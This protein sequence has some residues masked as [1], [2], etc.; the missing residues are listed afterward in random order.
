MTTIRMDNEPQIDSV[1]AVTPTEA[2]HIDP[3]HNTKTAVKK[4]KGQGA[5]IWI[6]VLGDTHR[7]LAEADDHMLTDLLRTGANIIQADPPQLL[8][9]YLQERGLHP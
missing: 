7:A 5:R 2:I 3:C 1:F 9:E 6:N 4:I 8:L